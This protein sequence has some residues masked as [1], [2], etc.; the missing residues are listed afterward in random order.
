MHYEPCSETQISKRMPLQPSPIFTRLRWW[1]S[2]G[3]DSSNIASTWRWTA[4]SYPSTFTEDWK[5]QSKTF[6]WN[7]RNG[8]PSTSYRIGYPGYM[9]TSKPEELKENERWGSGLHPHWKRKWNLDLTWNLFLF[10]LQEEC[11]QQRPTPFQ[12][13]QP[14]Q[15]LSQTGIHE[16]TF[17][18]YRD[19][20]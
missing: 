5:I 4:T 17:C 12:W 3:H 11:P 7:K 13:L 16:S 18:G 19:H 8:G 20:R 15:G 1:W 6:W 14:R 9:P 10:Q 2:T